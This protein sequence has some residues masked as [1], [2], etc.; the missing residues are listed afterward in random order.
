MYEVT[1]ATKARHH[2]KKAIINNSKET[3]SLK[4]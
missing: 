1:K 4:F 3:K 2:C